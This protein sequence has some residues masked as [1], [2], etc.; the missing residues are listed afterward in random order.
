VQLGDATFDAAAYLDS[1]ASDAVVKRAFGAA[2]A[3]ARILELLGPG[4]RLDM[5]SDGIGASRIRG[6]YAA[7]D[8]PELPAILALLEAIQA[9]LPRFDVAEAMP[10]PNQTPW[11]LI[12]AGVGMALAIVSFRF[13]ALAR[14]PMDDVDSLKGVG[15][16]LFGWALVLVG[17]WAVRRGKANSVGALLVASILLFF[18]VPPLA[19]GV[20]FAV[21]SGM[22]TGPVTTHTVQISSLSLSLG[23]IARCSF[24]PGGQGGSPTR[25]GPRGRS[26]APSRRTTRSRS[27]RAPAP[28]AGRGFL[29]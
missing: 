16:G 13:I 5:S 18:A 10:A 21:N 6:Y 17:I 24:P 2:E 4:Y 11:T 14:P 3:R 23:A 19:A 8:A 22:D 9:A 27:T 1:A 29:Q 12:A 26:F 7:F 15:I 25:W 20:I 28:S